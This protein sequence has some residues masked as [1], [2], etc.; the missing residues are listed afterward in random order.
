MNLVP[1]EEKTKETSKSDYELQI[2]LINMFRSFDDFLSEIDKVNL[3]SLH[4]GKYMTRIV[5]VS[6]EMVIELQRAKIRL[7]DYSEGSHRTKDPR[8]LKKD[9]HYKT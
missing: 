7:W 3:H 9:N 4:T 8:R 5:E 2:K 6:Q 1:K